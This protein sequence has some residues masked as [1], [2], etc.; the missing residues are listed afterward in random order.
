M[1]QLK[2]SIITPAFN[3]GKTIEKTILSVLSQNYNNLEY[4]IIDGASSDNTLE[5]VEKYRDKI[6]YIV[7]EKDSGISEA[8]NKGIA[9]STGE[10]IGIINSDDYL[11]PGA[12]NTVAQAYDG[13]TDIYQGNI[14]LENP[15]TGF[16]CREIPSSHFPTM[17]FFCH[18]AH[19]GMFVTRKA[20]SSFGFYDETIR[21]PMD[22]EFLMRA[23]RLGAR[24]KHI[25]ADLAVFVAGGFT[26]H[27]I[28]IKKTD[29]LN[30]VFKNGGNLLQ[31][32]CYYYFLYISQKIKSLLSVFSKDISQKLRYGKPDYKK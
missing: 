4:I 3:S 12:L 8:F 19:Q 24:F 11:L 16:I 21:W 9:L 31:A 10:I 15:E 14:L 13:I 30:I 25:E 2:I 18:V 1:E 32:Y 17:P 7:S 28:A 6:S 20:Y 22:L 26:S 5:I 29:Y 23:D 27:N